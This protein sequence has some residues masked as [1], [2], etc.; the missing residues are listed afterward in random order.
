MA[1]SITDLERSRLRDAAKT[2]LQSAET[3]NY[4]LGDVILAR[5]DHADDPSCNLVTILSKNLP[6]WLRDMDEM[7]D[8]YLSALVHRD[9]A[10]ARIA[11]ELLSDARASRPK[12]FNVKTAS[13]IVE[14]A[15]VG[16]LSTRGY[17]Q[18][19][20][21]PRSKTA[22]TA[23]Y[24]CRMNDIPTCLEIKNVNSPFGIFDVFDEMLTEKKKVSS[25][26][27]SIS[28]KLYCDDDNTATEAQKVEIDRFLDAIEGGPIPEMH[29][30]QLSGEV[31]LRV[32]VQPGQ[33]RVYMFRECILGTLCNIQEDKFL[34]KV[35]DTVTSALPQLEK[36]RHQRRVLALNII[37]PDAALPGDWN[38]KIRNIVAELSGGSVLSEVLFY[39]KYLEPDSAAGVSDEMNYH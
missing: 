30:V 33:G 18:F 5:I 6:H 24:E 13:F 26:F 34:R 2:A 11:D 19:I 10:I 14:M 38:A 22:K 9:E 28:L 36:C 1:M 31:Q 15:A 25:Y 35:T 17:S 29:E 27:K 7:C 37:T 20:P 23:D 4:L 16:E 3:L 32:E 8:K 12:P 21:I 39:Q